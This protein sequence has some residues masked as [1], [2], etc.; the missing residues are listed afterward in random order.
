MNEMMKINKKR[1]SWKMY[2]QSLGILFF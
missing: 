2:L 1:L